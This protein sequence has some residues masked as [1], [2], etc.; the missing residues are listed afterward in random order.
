MSPRSRS[1]GSRPAA[2]QDRQVD[3]LGGALVRG[4]VA[5]AVD[6]AEHLAGVG[7]RDDQRVVAPGAVVGDVHALLAP[8]PVATRVPSMSMM[9]SSKK[10][11]GCWLQTLTPG[12]V[13]DVLEGL[14]VVGGEAAAEV[15]GGGGVGDAVGAQGV[16]EDLVVAAQFDVVEAGAVA[17]GV[18]GEVEDV[19]G[20]VV[21]EVELEQ[22]EALV[23]GLGEAELAD[24]EVDGADAAVG[25]GPGLG[26]R[27][28]SGCW[29]R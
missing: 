18:V 11:G 22:V 28:R 14:D 27:S 13:E 7:Q 25:D 9:A 5:G 21:G 15:A 12:L 8:A 26:R 4:P 16:E 2:E 1:G 20:L 24:Q 3:L 23:D 19:V 29:R 17:Q 6:E 10:S